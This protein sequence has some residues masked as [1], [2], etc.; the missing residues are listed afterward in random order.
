MSLQ[1]LKQYLVDGYDPDTLVD[2]LE[3]ESWEIVE[4]FSDKVEEY[5]E[6]EGDVVNENAFWNEG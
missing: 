5:R 6:R 2:I 4:R 3:I 1:Q